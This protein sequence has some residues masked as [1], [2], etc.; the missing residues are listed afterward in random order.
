[1]HVCMNRFH[2]SLLEGPREKR[3]LNHLKPEATFSLYV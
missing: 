3:T 1:M 2:N